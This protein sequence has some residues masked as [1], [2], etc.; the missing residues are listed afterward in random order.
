MVVSP[1]I[2]QFKKMFSVWISADDILFT[3]LRPVHSSVSHK[4]IYHTVK[5]YIEIACF[6]ERTS[7]T[8][9][10][11]WNYS[12]TDYKFEDILCIVLHQ[13]PGP[14][15]GHSMDRK[16]KSEEMGD[17]WSPYSRQLIVCVKVKPWDSKFKC[18]APLTSTLPR[19][20]VDTDSSTKNDW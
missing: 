16:W 6:Y 8:Q 9:V 4:C 1:Y 14:F 13:N 10:K 19:D 17:V 18:I 15:Q 2:T 20:V 3:D 12:G 5:N 11:Y 7:Q